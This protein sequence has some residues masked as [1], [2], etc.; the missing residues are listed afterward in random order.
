MYFRF[1]MTQHTFNLSERLIRVINGWNV[2]PKDTVEEILREGADVNHVHGLCLPLHCACSV[3]NPAVVELLLDYGAEVNAIDGF[4]RSAMHCAAEGSTDCL[5]VLVSHGGDVDISDNNRNRP[6]HWAAYRNKDKSVRFL[7]EHGALV[8]EPDMFYNTPLHWA[9]M[10]SSLEAIR[11]L[12]DFGAE[13][14]VRNDSGHSPVL[15]AAHMFTAGLSTEREWEVLNLLLK[16]AGNVR[17]C[18]DDGQIPQNIF[19]DTDLM[20]LLIPVCYTPRSLSQLCRYNI[21]K[22]V[23]ERHVNKLIMEL[24]LPDSLLRF[25]LLLSK[26]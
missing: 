6:L 21:R 8:N 24:P 3:G 12:L 17:I 23:G 1:A 5:Q 18:D 7:L 13:V 2:N 14:T 25:L 19:Q 26:E 15:K 11:V 9:T 20:K 10:K 4:G 16:A 22:S